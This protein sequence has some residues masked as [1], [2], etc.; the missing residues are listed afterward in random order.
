M[1]KKLLI[2]LLSVVSV[3]SLVACGGNSSSEQPSSEPVSS[4]VSEDP[5]D[6]V[7]E[8]KSHYSWV[9]QGDNEIKDPETGE[10]INNAWNGGAGKTN[11]QY[12][13]SAIS[14]TSINAVKAIDAT[15]GETLESKNVQYLYM[16]EVRLGVRKSGWTFKAIKED[17]KIYVRDGSF[18]VKVCPVLYVEEDDVFTEDGWIPNAKTH[19]VESLTPSTVWYPTWQEAADEN[20]FSWANDGGCIGQAGV[21]TI[22]VAKYKEVSAADVPGYGVALVLKEAGTAATED[23]EYVPPVEN[24]FGVVGTINNWG[25]TADTVLVKAGAGKFEA[26]VELAAGDEIKVRANNTWGTNED[27]GIAALVPN[28][29]FEG[30]GNIVCKVAGTYKITLE[31]TETPSE[32]A[33]VAPTIDWTTAKITITAAA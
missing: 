20:G 30:T 11:E 21:Y 17:G 24:S 25:G 32:T 5:N 6:K 3:V 7:L 33:G 10:W 8:D 29:N 14:A 19:H 23:V 27:A 16:G 13:K 18:A 15:L 22:V 26:T 28:D 2:G 31:I 12:E 9:I 1:N 4:E